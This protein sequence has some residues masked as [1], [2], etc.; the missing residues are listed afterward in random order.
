[1]KS[2][3]VTGA[4]SGIGKATSLELS[5]QGY[6]IYLMGRDRDR[7][8]AV[9]A[10][11]RY[12]ASILSCDLHQPASVEA[13]LDEIVNH[14]INTLEILVNN[15]GVFKNHTTETGSDEIWIEQFQ[16]NLLSAVRI[17]R[18][19]LPYF[20]E[21]K[22]GSIVNV[23]STL[24]LKPTENTG[25][26]SAI[27]AAMVN[28]T[29]SLALEGGRFNIRV[30]CVCPGLVDTPIH[31]FHS[32]PTAEKSKVLDNLK[33]VQPLGRVGQPEEVAKAIAFLATPQSS[34]TTGA[35]LSV[36]G[37]INIK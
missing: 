15:A 2:A 24:G 18:R 27:K 19:L 14:K 29:Q 21:H 20:K 3:L 22:Q 8:E 34:W 26:Y 37:G 25:A 5:R 35:V 30:N 7:L 23:S 31:S 36:D 33:N 4:S 10:E 28:W 9:A 17:V 32:L 6:F 13:R 12:G 16:V 1:M 11:C